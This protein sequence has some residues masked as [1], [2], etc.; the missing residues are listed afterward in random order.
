M[1]NIISAV[2][3]SSLL[4]ISLNA[5]AETATGTLNVTAVALGSCSIGTGGTLSFDNYDV[6]AIADTTGNTGTSLQVT[7][8]GGTTWSMYST[9][10][11]VTRI[12]QNT[13]IATAT[14]MY[15][16]PYTLY[17]DVAATIPLAVTNTTGT[18]TGTGTGSPETAMIYGKIS[19]GLNVF[20][21]NYAQV[22]N[23]TLVY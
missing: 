8:N 10:S 18:V 5:S 4:M 15:Q 6:D 17:T 12:M 23:L 1:K 11:V 3:T 19:K 22:I 20:T 21:G 14:A 2:I 7:C 13:T 9:E 16:L